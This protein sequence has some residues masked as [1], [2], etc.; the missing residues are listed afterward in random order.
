MPNFSDMPAELRNAVYSELLQDT[1]SCKHPRRTDNEL[2]L[3][4]VSKQLHDE[5]TSY[6]YQHN[7]MDI[8]A[9][10]HATRTAT[11]LPPIADKYLQFLRRL[12]IYATTAQ[13]KLPVAQRVAST[14]ATLATIGANFEE[15]HILIQSPLSKLINSRVDDSIMDAKHPITVALW[16]LL[17][18]GVAKITRIELKNAWFATGVAQALHAKYDSRLQFL[19]NAKTPTTDFVV[20]ERHLTGHFASSHLTSLGLDDNDIADAHCSD[21]GS[22]RSTP[23]SLPSSLCSAFADIDTFSVDSF[24][25]SSDDTS[26]IGESNDKSDASE[27]PF[28]TEDDIEEWQNSTQE[29]EEADSG[30]YED[31]EDIDVDED[32]EIEDVPQDFIDALMSGMEK[33]AHHVAAEADM[34]YITNFA[35]DLLL[36]INHLGH[37]V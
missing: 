27:Q 20:L 14:I 4:T 5:S 33:T 9:P 17:E 15:L 2:A 36:H 34:T 7:G 19:L 10:T 12:T 35:P 6:F 22:M 31:L 13:A 1:Q 18:S 3:F 26:E 30:G 21:A 37:L 23:S 8:D 24:R 25:L 32:V 28:F 16:N 11:I 29:S